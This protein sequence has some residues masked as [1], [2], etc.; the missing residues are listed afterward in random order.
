MK[1]ILTCAGL[2]AVGAV[3]LQAQST[4]DA[5]PAKPW[6]VS[7]NVRG[8]YDDNYL[9]APSSRSDGGVTKQGSWGAAITPSVGYDIISDL[10]TLSAKATYDGRWYADRDSDKMD[11]SFLFDLDLKHSFSDRYKLGVYD[12][13]VY[14]IEP[15]LLAPDSGPTASVLRSDGSGIRNSSGLTFDA[16][17]TEKFGVQFHYANGLYVYDD[18]DD[19]TW[20]ALLDRIEN[21]PGLDFRYKFQPTFTGLVGYQYQWVDYT[22]DNK[23]Y[24]PTDPSPYNDPSIRNNTSHFAYIGGEHA[25]NTR[26]ATQARVGVQIT[27][28]QNVPEPNDNNV[29]GPYADASLSYQYS[30]GSN[31]ILGVK[32]T[33]TPTDVASYFGAVPTGE[34]PTTLDTA[35]TTT[36]F[37]VV[38][39]ITA[40]LI[41]T[42]RAQW[43]YS[44]FNG[45]A[46]NGQADNYYGF[47]AKL[48]YELTKYVFA[49]GG[50]GFD[51]LDSDL[52]NRSFSRNRVW[53]GFRG[54]F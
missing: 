49:E 50:Y 51:R 3:S 6:N 36:Y 15:L 10:T 47:D 8:F 18:S 13:F 7:V 5:Q 24:S 28:F 37:A 31:L 20:S 11:H 39:R 52:P 2:A 33:R 35:S 44:E 32:H 9:T 53:L 27:D 48:A 42:G 38:H 45:G 1:R 22:S 14:S 21:T 46:A 30:E 26:F 34:S 23:L 41:A 19:T 25:W 16:S 4:G 40:K 12:S 43:Q 54:S 17:M 29:V